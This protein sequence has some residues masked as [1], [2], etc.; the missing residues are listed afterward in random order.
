MR[1]DNPYLIILFCGL[2]VGYA[3]VYPLVKTEQFRVTPSKIAAAV[4]ALGIAVYFRSLLLFAGCLWPLSLIWF[5]EYW[6]NY[7]GLLQGAY[8][9]QKSP[10]FAVALLG[11]LLLLG[12]PFAFRW[13]AMAGP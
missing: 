5:S 3:F 9:R 2:F 1:I 12:A 13:L 7:T 11:W 4:I 6:G 8:I 10:P